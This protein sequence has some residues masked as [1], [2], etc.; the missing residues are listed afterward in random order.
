MKTLFLSL[1]LLAS[2]LSAAGCAIDDAGATPIVSDRVEAQPTG[3]GCTLLRP[4][5][6]QTNSVKRCKEGYKTQLSMYDGQEYTAISINS[7][8][9]GWGEK[10]VR[11]QNGVIVPVEQTCFFGTQQ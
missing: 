7:G 8:G 5:A 6:W 2:T 3:T 4:L 9:Y 1:S 11:C 10:T